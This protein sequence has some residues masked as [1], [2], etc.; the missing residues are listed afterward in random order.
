M[1]ANKFP[2]KSM[3]ICER[4]AHCYTLPESPGLMAKAAN[5]LAEVAI[6]PGPKHLD[7]VN[8]A[9]TYLYSTHYYT[10]EYSATAPQKKSSFAPAM[11][12]M[13]I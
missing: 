6:N 5:K 13:E 10:L 2:P 11:L 9:I 12:A 8:R 1:M 7:T 4:L 3:S